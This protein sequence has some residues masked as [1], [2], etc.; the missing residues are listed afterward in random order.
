MEEDEYLLD[1]MGKQT[2]KQQKY[3]VY[4]NIYKSQYVNTAMLGCLRRTK[5]NML[6][7]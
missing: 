5:L 7:K 6:T 2:N 3:I 4:I 1:W